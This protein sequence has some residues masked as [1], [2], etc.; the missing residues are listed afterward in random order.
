MRAAVLN[1]PGV[2]SSSS[3]SASF[4]QVPAGWASNRPAGRPPAGERL[5]LGALIRVRLGS[6]EPK[7]DSGRRD[8]GPPVMVVLNKT[9]MPERNSNSNTP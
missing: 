3:S 4:A 9:S 5:E 7:D 8:R 1:C 2:V 6:V